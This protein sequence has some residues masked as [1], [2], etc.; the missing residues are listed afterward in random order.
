M[1][2]RIVDA[3][4]ESLVDLRMQNNINFVRGEFELQNKIPKDRS[5]SNTEIDLGKGSYGEKEDEGRT[6]SAN[7]INNMP[8]STNIGTSSTAPTTNS[9]ILDG[10][11][12][13]A[14]K[15]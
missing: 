12:S 5:A 9:L 4:V 8:I 10:R 6:D 3:S 13:N 7:N 11:N 15:F 2:K 14:K 1:I